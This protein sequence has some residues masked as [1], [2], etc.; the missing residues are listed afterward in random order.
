MESR[1]ANSLTDSRDKLVNDEQKA[2][3]TTAFDRQM[4]PAHPG[5]QFHKLDRARDKNFSSVRVVVW[6]EP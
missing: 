5:L 2:G 4:N 6:F 1:N 3:K